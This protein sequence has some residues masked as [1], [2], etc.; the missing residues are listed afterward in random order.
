MTILQVRDVYTEDS[1][2]LNESFPN[3]SAG[4]YRNKQKKN[5]IIQ[6]EIHP[7]S[8]KHPLNKEEEGGREG[9]RE[10][11]QFEPVDQVLTF[12][13]SFEATLSMALS[14]PHVAFLFDWSFTDS[15]HYPLTE[16]GWNPSL[17]PI[18]PSHSPRCHPALPQ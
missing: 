2:Q 8:K 16:I 4:S 17:N 15:F 13:R 11:L 14:W 18:P 7:V 5:R 9:G 6:L 3:Q 10:R 1:N 12:A